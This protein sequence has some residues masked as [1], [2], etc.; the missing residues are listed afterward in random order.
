MSKNTKG[1]VPRELSPKGLY[2]N[3][4]KIK[5]FFLS[6]IL[7]IAALLAASQISEEG[8]TFLL[9]LSYILYY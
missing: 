1:R 7:E 3:T 8:N 5:I 2:F 6:I 9:F 4:Y